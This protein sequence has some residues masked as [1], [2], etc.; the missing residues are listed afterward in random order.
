M[1]YACLLEFLLLL[2]LFFLFFKVATLPHTVS[3]P[4]VGRPKRRER[5]TPTHATY[6]I[7]C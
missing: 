5:E 1:A 3:E 2:F 6:H 7:R 4:V